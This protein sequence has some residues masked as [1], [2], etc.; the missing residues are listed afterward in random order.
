[1]GFV[2]ARWAMIFG[3]LRVGRE[4]AGP[5]FFLCVGDFIPFHSIPFHLVVLLTL[6]HVFADVACTCIH[7]PGLFEACGRDPAL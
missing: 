3:G 1:V 6:S 4:P 5:G 2:Q 7:D